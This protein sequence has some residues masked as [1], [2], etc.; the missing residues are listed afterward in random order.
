MR[1]PLIAF[2]L[3]W[4]LVWAC[5]GLLLA[6]QDGGFAGAMKA[7]ADAGNLSIFWATFRAW[8]IRASTHAH[9]LNFS[10]FSIIL[11]LLWP[12]IKLPRLV[13]NTAAVI[14]SL[15]HI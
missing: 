6:L 1:T 13:K 5:V 3:G 4:I 14:L 7:A 11:G 8:K 9:V 12:M 10:Y 15:I 2:G